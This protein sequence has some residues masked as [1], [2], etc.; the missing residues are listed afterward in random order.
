STVSGNSAGNI[1]GGISG[2]GTI[3]LTNSIVL[4][5]SAASDAEIIGTVDTTGGGNIVGEGTD[6]DASDGMINASAEDVFAQT[7]ELADGTL[8]GGLADN[9]GPV[10][11]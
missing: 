8:A 5:N 10:E 11:T 3:S 2:P 1:G 9:G 7:Y 6:T 4:G